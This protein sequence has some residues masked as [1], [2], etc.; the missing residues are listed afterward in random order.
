[1]QAVAFEKLLNSGEQCADRL[2]A[3]FSD[4]RDWQQLMHIA[5]DGETY[6]HHHR[7]GDMALAYALKRIQDRGDARL[8][9]YGEFLERFPPTHEVQIIER[10]AWS[11]SHGL[12]RWNSHCGCNS[13]VSW[14]Q[15]WRG[16]LRASL[17]WLRDAVNAIS[18]PRLNTFFQDSWAAR[19]AYIDVVL[20]RTPEANEVFFAEHSSQELDH[21]GRSDALKLM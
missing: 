14:E 15:H 17:D 10:T 2:A 3:G 19:N 11:C 8:I 16:P 13:G 20:D 21:S 6:G 9:N 5:T 7:H 1:S 4:H 12:E 18:E